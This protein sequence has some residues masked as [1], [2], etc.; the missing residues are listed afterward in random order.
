MLAAEVF[1]FVGEIQLAGAAPKTVLRL[2]KPAGVL[3][4]NMLM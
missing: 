3:P 1:F 2:S 4:K